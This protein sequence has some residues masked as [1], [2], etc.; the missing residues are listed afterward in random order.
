MS[1]HLLVVGPES[2]PGAGR[3]VGSDRGASVGSSPCRGGGAGRSSRRPSSPSAARCPA[4]R[5]PVIR[6]APHWPLT[7]RSS[8]ALETVPLAVFAST[9]AS[10]GCGQP[11]GDLA[12]DVVSRTSVGPLGGSRSTIMSPLTDSARTEGPE[13]STTVR[14]PET[15]LKR[16][17]PVTA[18][19]SRL[20]E[21]VSARTGPERPTS[22]VSPV[23][24]LTSV[25]PL[26]PETTAAAPTTPTSTRVPAGTARETTARAAPA[27]AVEPLEEALPGEVLVGHREDSVLLG[28]QQ[29]RAVDLGDLQAGRTVVG[30]DHVDRAVDDAHVQRPSRA[31]RR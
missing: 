18:W 19:A 8:K 4:P 29:R 22:V 10:A 16:R 14:S 24:P 12:R 31:R 26:T 15:E 11:D 3:L 27:L 25:R 17:S 28:H 21:T 20:P 30:A 2:P 6:L 23:T 7:R 13:P 5:R 1:E 9:S